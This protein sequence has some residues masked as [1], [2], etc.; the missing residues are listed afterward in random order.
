[1]ARG[2]DIRPVIT[3]ISTNVIG[4]VEDVEGRRASGLGEEAGGTD[5]ARR[6][7][8]DGQWPMGRHSSI[9]QKASREGETRLKLVSV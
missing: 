1:M 6:S 3:G 7:K 5:R 9:A 2:H 4:C 8:M